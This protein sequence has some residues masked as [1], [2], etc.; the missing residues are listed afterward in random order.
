MHFPIYLDYMATTPVDPRV[1]EVM[2]QYLT[3]DG[4][5]GNPS[6]SSHQ[7]GWQAKEAVEK[8]RAQVADLINAEPAEILWTSCAT[9]ASNLA[10]KGACCCYQRKGKHIITLATE[11][12]SVLNTCKAMRQHGFEVTI[13]TPE[14]DGILDLKKLE[15]ALRDDTILVSIMAV[16]NEIGVIQ[17][18]E[19]IGKL[20]KPKGIIFHVDA[21][22]AAGKI[23]I[24][25][26]KLPV[27]FMSFSAHKVYGPK[28]V[29]CLFINHHPRIHCETQMHGG[30][31]EFG[32]RSGTLPVHQIAA[33]GE[34]FA[35]AKAEMVEKNQ[36]ITKMRDYLW[37][38][39]SK[40]PGI[41]LNGHPEKRVPHNLNMSFANIR[42][43]NL[44]KALE[45]LAISTSSAC[46]SAGREPSYVLKA[47]GLPD[48]LA[49][50]SIRLSIGNY[51]TQEHIEY[52]AN[53]IKQAIESLRD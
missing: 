16:N 12:K 18:I 17:D 22:Q 29:G 34:A 19:A 52:A 10:I 40:I 3:M 50:S 2:D 11:H 30:G 48:N 36:R 15:D 26:R 46:V 47:L 31:H 9:E 20:L 51:T 35:I 1:K 7:Y 4:I 25:V 28:G 38:E 41:Q 32:L 8:A 49:F 21:V 42:S 39:L 27:D 33:M 53:Y 5:F 24:D 44:V 23:D 45:N 43:D 6:S 37:G 14:Q 13:L